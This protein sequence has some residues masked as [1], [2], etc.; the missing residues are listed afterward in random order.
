MEKWLDPQTITIWIIIVI[1]IITLLAV[2]FVKLVRLNFKR[3]VATQLKDSRIQLEHQKKLLETGIIAQE[4]ERTRI[5]ADLHDSLIGKLTVLRLK[6]QTDYNYNDIDALLGESIAEARRISHDLSPP[7]LEFV[8]VE[9]I[10]DG[11][12]AS[13]KKQMKINFLSNIAQ[14][15]AIPNNLKIQVTRIT[16]ELIIN[17]H[18]HAQCSLVNVYLKITNKCLIL[19]VNDN[20]KG[21]DMNIAKKGIGLKNIELRMLYLNGLHKIKTGSKGTTAIMILN[22]SKFEAE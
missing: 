14:G 7:M 22:H 19:I 1:A 12:V 13:W 20:G 16:Q 18:K 9:E 21:F 5:A 11:I 8:S 3:M 17:I 6:N 2:S 10:L 15:A 4:Q